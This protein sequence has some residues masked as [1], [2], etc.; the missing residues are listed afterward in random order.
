[1]GGITWY[2][3]EIMAASRYHKS[4]FY[5]PGGDLAPLGLSYVGIPD[6]TGAQLPVMFSGPYGVRTSAT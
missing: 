3:I 2:G 5:L 1:M 6:L 4:L